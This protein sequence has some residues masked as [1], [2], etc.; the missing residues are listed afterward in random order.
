MKVLI[1][2]DAIEFPL[3]AFPL[4]AVQAVTRLC[5]GLTSIFPL[6]SEPIQIGKRGHQDQ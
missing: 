2:S 4:A 5:K 1:D 3:T 6:R